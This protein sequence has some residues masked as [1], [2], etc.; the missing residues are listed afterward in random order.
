MSEA[1]IKW[2][3]W[4]PRGRDII[5][6]GGK[7]DNT[8]TFIASSAVEALRRIAEELCRMND[9]A[10]KPCTELNPC[11]VCEAAAIVKP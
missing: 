11:P 1:K 8:M 3:N 2:E 5:G 10:T 4:L 7:K 9:G 6:T